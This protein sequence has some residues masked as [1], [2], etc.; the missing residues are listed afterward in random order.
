MLNKAG[1][2]QCGAC[3]PGIVMSIRWLRRHA[4]VAR[5]VDLRQFMSGNLCRCTGYDGVIAGVEQA[6]K[7][8][9]GD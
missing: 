4:E 6:L 2:A 5:R 7:P 3:S 9:E 1:T 8:D